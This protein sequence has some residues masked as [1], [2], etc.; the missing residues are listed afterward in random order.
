[1][2]EISTVV[3][4]VDVLLWGAQMGLVAIGRLGDI[5]EPLIYGD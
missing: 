1:M 5:G 4:D 2:K 3:G